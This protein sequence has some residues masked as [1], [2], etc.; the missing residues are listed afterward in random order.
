MSDFSRRFESAARR[1]LHAGYQRLQT[2]D[3]RF[4][5]R[6]RVARLRE[7]FAQTQR[8]LLEGSQAG[9]LDRLREIRVWHARLE[10]NEGDDFETITRSYRRLIRLYHP[11]LYAADPA[12]ESMANDV[13]QGI[14][15]AYE[16][17]SRHFNR[18]P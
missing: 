12:H 4:G 14:N 1:G 18:R 9:G 17:L 6:E 16:G 8:L 13:T 3:D 5:V 2:L 7:D 15:T 10:V 11:D